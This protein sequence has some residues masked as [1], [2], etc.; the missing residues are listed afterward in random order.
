M[1]K[2]VFVLLVCFCIVIFVKPSVA[3]TC[4]G[5][6]EF[7]GAVNGHTYCRS[8]SGMTWWAAFAWCKKQG[9]ELASID[10]LCDSWNGAIGS[11]ICSNMKVDQ[12]GYWGWSANPIGSSRAYY[13]NLTSG[14][15]DTGNSRATKYYAI[16]Y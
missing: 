11:D 5:G 12:S 6:K 8:G 9:R 16:C 2:M 4:K 10:Q 13:F 3:G 1:K 15:Y 7:Q 14:Q